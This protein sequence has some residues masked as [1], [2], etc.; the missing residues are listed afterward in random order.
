MT[1]IETPICIIG[2]G[3][4]GAA[5]SI[6]LT[7][8]KIEHIIIDA[9][10]FP[11]D[12]VCGDGLEMKTIAALNLI[13][14]TIVPYEM[15][16]TKNIVDC[17][18]FRLI[19]QN[20]KEVDFEFIPPPGAERMPAYGV[21]RRFVFDNLLVNRI[22]KNVL[23][24]NCKATHIE[25]KGDDW[26]ITCKH[27]N[28][29]LTIKSKFL[30]GAD[31]DHSLVLKTVGERKINRDHY[32][33]AVRQYWKGISGISSKNFMEFYYPKSMPMSYFW[34]FPLQNGEA[35]VGFGT[36]S[37]VAAKQNIN[38]REEFVKIIKEDKNIA[39][40]FANATS[41]S[42]IKGW[43]LPMASLQRN[44]AGEG[45][46]LLGDAGSLISPTTGEGIGT[47][48]LGSYVAAQ[49]IERAVKQNNFSHSMFKNYNRE[50]YKRMMGDI[51][52]FNWSMKVSPSFMSWLINAVAGL[53]IVEKTFQKKVMK[54]WYNAYNTKPKINF[55]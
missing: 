49:F 14:K 44:N 12:K 16:E 42:D 52:I 1:S 29:P 23:C 13:D 53:K 31:G 20:G 8:K 22:D 2:A 24:Q 19:K 18:G 34:I 3:P 41:L 25:K 35:N 51:K 36:L 45:W 9:A 28:E 33:G 15:F 40:R 37:S 21:S 17:W 5:L 48:M 54:W 6:L 7:Q 32:A 55:D 27:H 46:L 47:S 50:V 39:P 38:V 30:I 4:S 11:R 10:Q 26:F 43:G